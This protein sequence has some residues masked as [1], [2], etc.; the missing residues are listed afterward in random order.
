MNYFKLS[1]ISLAKRS[2]HRQVA[3]KRN[4]ANCESAKYEVS[5]GQV[6]VSD[7]IEVNDVTQLS[8]AC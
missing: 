7:A 1:R 8:C 6:Q 2:G 3:A 4:M 5:S